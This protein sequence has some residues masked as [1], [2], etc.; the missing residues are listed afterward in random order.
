M[1]RYQVF[2][3]FCGVLRL[4]HFF[5]RKELRIIWNLKELSE[6]RDILATNNIAYKVITRNHGGISRDRTGSIG[7]RT[8]AV[9]QYYIYVKKE[10]YE[11]ARSLIG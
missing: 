6:I 2:S 1:K 4:I 8:D 5:N 10:D 3:V 9:Y 11:K 7:M